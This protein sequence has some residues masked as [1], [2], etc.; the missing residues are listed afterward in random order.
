MEN[1]DILM[2]LPKN[3]I[4]YPSEM[5][6][7][8]EIEKDGGGI[9][10][11]TKDR[12]LGHAEWHARRDFGFERP[13]IN[14]RMIDR[15]EEMKVFESLISRIAMAYEM[16]PNRY[17]LYIRLPQKHTALIAKASRMGFIP[18]FGEWKEASKDQSVKDWERIT[19]D[20]RREFPGQQ[21]LAA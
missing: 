5:S 1:Q 3:T 14:I 12:L 7:D 19:E 9:T 6:R 16:M 18:Y 21:V 15:E 10:I 20:L 2:V 17:P 13:A 8:W 4:H 11:Y